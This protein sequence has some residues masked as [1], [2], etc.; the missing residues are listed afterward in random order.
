VPFEPILT[1]E[2]AFK[3]TPKSA[4][5]S[6]ASEFE[7]L[8]KWFLTRLRTSNPELGTV[9]KCEVGLIR[10]EPRTVKISFI[11]TLSDPAAFLR[12]ILSGLPRAVRGARLNYRCNFGEPDHGSKH[13]GGTF[14]MQRLRFSVFGFRFSAHPGPGRKVVIG[15]PDCLNIVVRKRLGFLLLLFGALCG[16]FV[17]GDDDVSTD[18]PPRT[19]E[20]RVPNTE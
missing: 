12:E 5:R 1:S 17:F 10:K 18:F 2:Q 11:A 14:K 8:S 20:N 19:G 13:R 7:L 9:R 4:F 6:G 15:E 3:L 16:S